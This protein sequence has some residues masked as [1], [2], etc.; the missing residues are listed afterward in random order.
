MKCCV[1]LRYWSVALIVIIPLRIAAQE[2]PPKREFRAVW[3]ATVSNIDFPLKN[4]DVPDKQR[5]DFIAILEQHKATGLNAVLVQV[6][7]TADALYAKSRE[8]WSQYLTGQQGKAPEPFWDPLVFMIEEAHKRGLEFHAWF[9]PYRSVISSSTALAPEH[10]SNTRPE[11]HLTFTSGSPYKLLNPGLQAVRE[12]V[13]AVVMDVVRG[14]DV[15]GIHFDDYF[16]PYSGIKNEDAATFQEF[17]RGITQLA[18]WRRDNINLL[19]RM[20]YDS[21]RAAK[22]WIKFGVSPFGI[23]RSGVP[24]GIVGMDAYAQIY[25]DALNWLEKRSVDYLIPQLYWAFGGGQDYGKLMPWWLGQTNNAGRHLYT[26]NGAYRLNG[27]SFSEQEIPNQIRFNR[28]SAALGACFFS[29]NSLTNNYKKVQDSLRTLF[30]T[31]ALPPV[32]AWKDSIAPE[33]PT[34]IS[35][36][37]ASRGYTI[38]WQ[39]PGKAADGDTAKYYA[40]Y[41]FA[42]GEPLKTNDPRFIIALPFQPTY[43]DT[44]AQQGISYT[45][46]ITALDRLHNESLPLIATTTDVSVRAFERDIT[47]DISPNPVQNKTT[48][49]FWLP[50]EQFTSIVMYDMLGRSVATILQEKR[51]SGSYFIEFDAGFLPEGMYVCRLTSG[52]F[53][54]TRQIIVRR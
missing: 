31:P 17:S 2:V 16:Y 4:T 26:G 52:I 12:Y 13:T 10:I 30:Q 19:I 21:I 23:W 46:A 3:I 5:A 48:F 29:S 35:I 40:V 49:H 41:R 24:A 36:A 20:V 9:N 37:N 43:N 54:H 51:A 1:L 14:Y 6:R 11:W 38:A 18:D 27:S 25:C 39:S 42:K 32:M 47:L 8:P 22:P 45:Y 15:D 50:R 44:S 53:S 7:P 28:Q 34:K 33:S